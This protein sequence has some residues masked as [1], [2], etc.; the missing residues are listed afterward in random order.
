V[1]RG[2]YRP[3]V[4]EQHIGVDVDG[5]VPAGELGRRRPVR[6]G[7]VAVQEAGGRHGER[8]GTDGDHAT[9]RGGE[10]GQHRGGHRDVDVGAPG[11]D[12]GVGPG[13]RA[14]VVRRAD[15]ERAGP[16]LVGRGADEYLVGR[17]ATRAAEHLDR[18]GQVERDH[19]VVGE[20]GNTG[21]VSIV[22]GTRR[23]LARQ[24]LPGTA[25][26]P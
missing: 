5:G 18:H 4:D 7:P 2:Q 1:R 11:D 16:H 21:H 13:Q 22:A 10:R 26:R 3:V 15:P 6:G 14:E 24:P 9:G 25:G 23:S 20:H 12:D 19:A 17:P 8:A